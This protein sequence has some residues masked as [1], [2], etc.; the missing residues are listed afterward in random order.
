M[1]GKSMKYEVETDY[2]VRIKDLPPETRPREKFIK[3]GPQSVSNAELLAILI[4]SGTK[5]ISA[6]DL[7][8]K[9][10]SDAGS[11]RELARK[12][13]GD[14]KKY[15]GIGLK[16]AV[17]I[18]AAFELSRRIQSEPAL[19]RP[20]I[21]SPD[22]IARIFIP[23]LADLNK[24][25]LI[26]VLLNT[27][28]KVIRDVVVSEGNLNSSVIH[29]REVFKPAIDELSASI[30]LVHNHPSGNPEPSRMDIEVTKQIYQA[31][32][33]LGIKLLDHVIIAGDKFTSMAQLGVLK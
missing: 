6:I 9:I 30:I 27:A 25:I 13:L 31:G 5:K 28:N 19:E 26:V 21:T 32:E 4:G 2:R 10:L 12:G 16:K 24:E 7:A 1:G 15:K 3:F 22:D 23:R 17:V 8:N 20:Q 33:I 18:S 11:L 29:P 14:L